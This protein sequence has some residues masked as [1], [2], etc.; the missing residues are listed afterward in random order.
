MPVPESR[1]PM[2][3]QR[4]NFDVM[5]AALGVEVEQ[6]ATHENRLEEAALWYRLTRR[7]PTR[8]PPSKMRD[9]PDEVSRNARRLL[10]S[11]GINSPAEAADGPRSPEL[12]AALVLLGE[13]NADPVIEA[14]GRIGR[15]TFGRGDHRQGVSSLAASH[16]RLF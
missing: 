6:V 4:S 8:I 14:V 15:L 5:A 3:P 1:I 9:K 2:V 13:R 11:W 16:R 10:K 7:R 12:L